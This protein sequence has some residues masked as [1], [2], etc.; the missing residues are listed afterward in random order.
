[1]IVPV[2]IADPM[3]R[4]QCQLLLT[5]HLS[6]LELC[7]TEAWARWTKWLATLEGAPTDLSPRTRANALHDF[8]TTEA[9]TRFAGQ[10]KVRVKRKR[11]LLVITIDDRIV[12]RF[13]K[14]RN[15]TLKVA[16][17][18]TQQTIAFD[19]QQ[20]QLSNDIVQPMTHLVVGYLLDSLD[21]GIATVAVTC[22]V[23]GAHFWAP[24][25]LITD[26]A[27][28]TSGVHAINTNDPTA[29]K[30]GVRSKRTTTV[31]ESSEGG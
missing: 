22:S 8:I 31:S 6:V 15:K 27:V 16:R 9:E 26:N 25:R 21:S 28:D 18:A 14:F 7:F 2:K 3:G 30:P 19:S 17:N 4:E 5:P 13:K 29:V 11:G 12:I 10:S 23:D 24:I 1:M 20:L